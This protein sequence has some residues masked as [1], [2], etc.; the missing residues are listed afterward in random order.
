MSL[1]FGLRGLARCPSHRPALRNASLVIS[2]TRRTPHISRRTIL[3]VGEGMT[4]GATTASKY[5]MYGTIGTNIT[6]FGAWWYSSSGPPKGRGL[7]DILGFNKRPATPKQH[8]RKVLE[9]NFVL[10][11]NDTRTGRWWTLLTSAFSHQETYHIVGNM[12]TLNA[13]MSVLIYYAG[14]PPQAMATLMLG[15]ALSGSVGFL[16]HERGYFGGGTKGAFYQQRAALGA[17][18][19]VMGLGAVAALLAPNVKLAL[20]G[21][22]PVPMW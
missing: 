12:F 4:W 15:S 8:V 9:E 21:I 3:G 1:A 17:S 11:T 13:F 20:M 6:V 19:M 14:V 7:K 22:V 5:L 10:H 16:M 2:S 18:G